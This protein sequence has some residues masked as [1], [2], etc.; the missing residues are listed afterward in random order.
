METNYKRGRRKEY[1]IVKRY[2]DFGCL[3]FRSAGSRSPVDVV[4]VNSRE[5][6]ILLIQS[7][8]ESMS[9]NKKEELRNSLKFLDGTYKVYSI[10]E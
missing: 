8:P 7:K 9:E 1:K 5:K 2:K 10:V 4:V 3:A 6:E